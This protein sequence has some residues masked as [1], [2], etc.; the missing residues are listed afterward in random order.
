LQQGKFIIK[1]AHDVKSILLNVFDF[2]PN[3][4]VANKPQCAP[5]RIPFILSINPGSSLK[6][7]LAVSQPFLQLFFLVPTLQRWN[8]YCDAEAEPFY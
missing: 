1:V 7:G 5:Q 2:Y 4:A 6:H 8:A 3:Q